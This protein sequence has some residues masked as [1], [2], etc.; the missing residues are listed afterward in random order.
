MSEVIAVIWDFDKTLIPGYMQEPIFKKYKINE[1]SFWKENNREI[2]KLEKKGLMVNHDTYYLNKFI[3]MSRMK[4][5]FY[6]LN[7]KKLKNLGRKIKFYNGA[8]KFLRKIKKLGK[9]KKYDSFDIV[10][11]NYIVSTGFLKMIQGSAAAPYAKK[12]WGADLI[13]KKKRLSSVVYSLDNTT[14]TRALFEI[15]KGV[16]IYE[17]SKIDVNTKIDKRLRRVRF[18][19]M[20]YIAD[21]PSDVPAFSVINQFGGG[22]LAVYPKGNKEALKQ[23]EQLRRDG[24]VQMIAEAD[25]SSGSTASMWIMNF[26]KDRANAIIEE[27]KR[28]IQNMGAGTPQHLI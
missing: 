28:A 18:E 5:G 21:G 12:I 13:E 22:T 6:G 26:I 19:N 25:Y 2:E 27:K 11:E 20:I 1:K 23:V 9:S 4:K 8:I 15:N 7:N 3:T 14:K 10:F 16:G 17:G 24:R